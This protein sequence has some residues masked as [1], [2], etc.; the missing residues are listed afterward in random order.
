[1]TH[2]YEVNTRSDAPP[3]RV[4]ALLADR[5]AWPTWAGPLIRWAG[6]ER[7]GTP[8]P[9][10]VGAIGQLGTRR[11]HSR[12]EI[13][14]YDPPRL[15]AYTILSGQPV[16]DYRADIRLDPDG[17]GT[18]IKWSATFRPL[19]PGT[20]ALLQVYLRAIIGG[21]AKRAAAAAV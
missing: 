5:L 6:W 13:V 11:F 19:I 18:S 17:D 15:I 4:F 16:R 8:A 7:E 3:E 2:S 14:A 12:E 9:G 20:G 1:M 10:G 21:V